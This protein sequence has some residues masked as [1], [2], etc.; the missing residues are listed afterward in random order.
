[1]DLSPETTA[2][3]PATEG[4]DFTSGSLCLDFV[5]T[6]S[7]HEPV[8]GEDLHSYAHVVEWARQAR[9]LDEEQVAALYGAAT[10]DRSAADA[11][12]AGTLALR[13]TIYRLVTAA[14]RERPASDEDLAAFN[15][16]LTANLQ[17]A[18]VAHDDEGFYRMWRDDV[19]PFDR[20]LWS[21]IDA[22]A[23]LLISPGTL[24]R[25]RHCAGERCDWLFI[26]NSRNHSRRWCSMSGCGNRAKA[27]RSYARRK[28]AAPPLPIEAAGS[29]S[30]SRW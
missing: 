24:S 19:L 2:A 25:L 29:P 22:A 13:E 6:A 8:T 23:G 21:V 11:A 30:E 17:N 16:A 4:Y 1:M 14:I 26:D 20:P 12:Y 3:T 10:D 5:N 28:R 7:T 9:L 18:R 27:K 15:S